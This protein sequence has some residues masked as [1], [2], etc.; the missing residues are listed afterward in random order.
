MTLSVAWVRA[1]VV[2]GAGPS[3][4]IQPADVTLGIPVCQVTATSLGGQTTVTLGQVPSVPVDPQG[5][6]YASSSGGLIVRFD[7]QGRADEAISCR[8]AEPS[9]CSGTVTLQRGPT[10]LASGTFSVPAYMK[11][12]SLVTLTA[13]ARTLLATR[14][15]L[16]ATLTVRN[17]SGAYA[18]QTVVLDGW[19]LPRPR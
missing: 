9:G 16:D 19:A 18:T 10:Q 12:H 4:D 6:A 1:G 2:V 8:T 11:G 3:Y 5:V 14:R 17:A 13:N 15:L 7:R